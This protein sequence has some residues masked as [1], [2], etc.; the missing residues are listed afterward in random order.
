MANGSVSRVPEAVSYR[1]KGEE[2]ERKVCCQRLPAVLLC[3][4][5]RLR[6]VMDAMI[7]S[8]RHTCP[9]RDAHAVRSECDCR[10]EVSA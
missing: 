1:D 9:A 10:Y 5:P 7:L 2:L 8:R 3:S 6:D 4:L